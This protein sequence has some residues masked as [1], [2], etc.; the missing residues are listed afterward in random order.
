MDC[1]LL[2]PLFKTH[3]KIITS[4]RAYLRAAIPAY[5]AK[6]HENAA[7]NYTSEMCYIRH[8]SASVPHNNRNHSSALLSAL[9]QAQAHGDRAI[10]ERQSPHI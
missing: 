3:S 10:K 4:A 1:N 6:E 5:C 2:I 7:H 8:D 9:G